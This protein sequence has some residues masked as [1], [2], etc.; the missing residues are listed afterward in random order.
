[1]FMEV[2]V[3]EHMLN[4]RLNI[5]KIK[6]FLRNNLHQHYKNHYEYQIFKISLKIST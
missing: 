2:N 1:M 5:F 4:F 3:M 6:I